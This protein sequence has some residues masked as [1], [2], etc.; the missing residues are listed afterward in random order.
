MDATDGQDFIFTITVQGHGKY[1]RGVDSIDVESLGVTWDDEPDEQDAFAYYTSQLTETDNFIRDLID[2]LDRRDEP[3]VLVLYGDHLPSFSIGA[4]QLEN[5]DIFQTEYVIWSNF[6]M[7]KDDEDLY[8]YQLSARVLEE[9]GL[10][11]GLLTRYHQQMWDTPDYLD[12]LKL[13]EYDMLYGSFYCYGGANP[14][15][16]TDLHMGVVPITISG[17]DFDPET[18]L[19]TVH[20]NN[21]TPW[22]VITLDGDELE[23]TF[24]P[25]TGDLTAV[26]EELA[27]PERTGAT[28]TVRQETA[29]REPL[30][31]S[32]GFI[33]K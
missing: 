27:D 31:E 15:T 20:G 22:S 10:S 30:S 6:R 4:E 19:L 18:E 3:T 7:K 17:C 13:L 29:K 11:P 23:T 21:F 9:L 16:A 26:A 2:A 24:D 1:Q 25:E 32:V 14:Y 12:G 8:A 33:M 28:I 5:G